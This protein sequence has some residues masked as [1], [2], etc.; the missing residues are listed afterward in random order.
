MGV[1]VYTYNVH[2]ATGLNVYVGVIFEYGDIT[3][4]T[5]KDSDKQV[6]HVAW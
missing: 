1:K 4:S 6:L 2:V 5:I 3:T